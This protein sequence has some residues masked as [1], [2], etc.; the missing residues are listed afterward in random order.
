MSTA[1]TSVG[2]VDDDPGVLESL[3]DLF[4]AAGYAVR[5][6]PSAEALLADPLG[7][8]LAC[9][10]TDIGLSGISGLE[11]LRRL[12]AVRPELPVILITGRHEPHFDAAAQQGGA[13]RL[14][15]KPLDTAQLL[16]TVD[17]LLRPGT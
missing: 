4:G 6:Y 9:V 14:L 16:G 7:L 15:T 8:H 12:H 5:R 1:R 11:L 17:G 2:I 3:A 13:Y 10:V